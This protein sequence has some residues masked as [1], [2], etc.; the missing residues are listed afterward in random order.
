MFEM[1]FNQCL[2]ASTGNH[3][4][5]SLILSNGRGYG[6]TGLGNPQGL[7]RGCRTGEQVSAAGWESSHTHDPLY[8][9]SGT[10]GGE[11]GDVVV[12]V[13][14]T[15]PGGQ[16]A[17]QRYQED[18]R[19][20]REAGSNVVERERQT[21]TETGRRIPGSATAGFVV[22]DRRLRRSPGIRRG[23]VVGDRQYRWRAIRQRN[24]GKSCIA[25]I[26]SGSWASGK[27]ELE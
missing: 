4:H 22:G 21:A 8:E 1:T 12:V 18:R 10:D 14:R 27:A 7:N 26:Q 20:M 11:A 16:S 2:S 24:T 17:G 6:D 19:L 5:S 13:V 9:S 25:K 3:K 15:E 23:R